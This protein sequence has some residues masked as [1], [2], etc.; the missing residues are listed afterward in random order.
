MLRKSHIVFAISAA[1]VI[2]GCA[3][4]QPAWRKESVS[5][6]GTR[7]ALAECK[8]QVG[9]NKIAEEKQNELISNCMEGK[10]YRWR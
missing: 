10:G 1:A 6:D 2:A 4:Y 3:S 8:Y 7:S 5:T 9:L